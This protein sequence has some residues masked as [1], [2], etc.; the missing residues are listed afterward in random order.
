[1]TAGGDC[2]GAAG[3]G[4]AA[5]AGT[6][7][8]AI[9]EDALASVSIFAITSP[10][11]TVPFSPFRMLTSTPSAGLGSSSTTLSVS[12]SIRF[13]SRF[14]A[15]PCFLCQASSVAS[16]TD[17]ES[18]GTFTSINIRTSPPGGALHGEHQVVADRREAPPPPVPS[19]ARCA[20]TGSPR[21]A[22]PKTCAWRR[23]AP[24]PGA[25]GAAG[26]AGCGARRPGCLAPPGTRTLPWR[27]RSG[28]SVAWNSSCGNG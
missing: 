18:C 22:T 4:F 14:T 13:S 16:E 2:R 12:M 10:A 11:T 17:S 26:S 25:C 9:D 24:G 3:T 5:A 23:R 7:A 6:A 20:A 8:A 28:R 1:M 27:W 15:S 21:R 19:A